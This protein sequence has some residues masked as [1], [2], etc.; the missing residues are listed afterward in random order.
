MWPDDLT[1]PA[2]CQ[3]AEADLL[4]VCA[5]LDS[6]EYVASAAVPGGACGLLREVADRLVARPPV[7]ESELASYGSI[8][9]NVYH[10]FRVLGRDRLALL[11]RV[12]FGWLDSIR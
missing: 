8:V 2:D 1:S 4:R 6:R 11:R 9:S 7:L 3:A 10:L 5:V 12:V